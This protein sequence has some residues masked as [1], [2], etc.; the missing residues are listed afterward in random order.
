M[1]ANREELPEPARRA[2]N[3]LRRLE[4]PPDLARSVVQQVE[5]TPQRRRA[6]LAGFGR[7]SIAPAVAIA[8]IAVIV[9]LPGLLP[10]LPPGASGNP[11]SGSAPSVSSLPIGGAIELLI[12]VP[13]GAHT[14]SADAAN[15]WL[16][17]ESTGAVI[18]LDAATGEEVGRVAV[19]E[20]TPEPYDLWPESDGTSVWVAG[21]DDRSLV[22]ID[23]ASMEIAARWPIDAIPYRILPGGDVV[24]ISDFDGDEVLAIDARDGRVIGRVTVTRPT[25]LAS[26]EGRIFAAG[27]AGQL[28]EIDP[29][30]VRVLAEHRIAAGASDLLALDGGLLVWGL[31][32]RPLERFDLASRAVTGTMAGPTAVVELGGVTWTAIT[33]DGE[34]ALVRIHPTTLAAASVIPLGTVTTDQLAASADRLWAYAETG[35][36]TFLYGAR[37]FP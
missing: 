35:G 23:I 11:P 4:P 16:G 6:T 30:E 21:R 24:W 1:T 12:P 13:D 22:R 25:G 8:L 32:R 18:R 31:N 27:Y 34:G 36:E 9:T 33:E 3:Q 5:A 37:P 14:G 17:Q 10:T 15:V 26:V 20:P 28:V 19:N 2:L 7:F 29:T